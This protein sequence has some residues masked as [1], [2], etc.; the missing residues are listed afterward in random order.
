LVDPRVKP[1]GDKRR[2]SE[3][4]KPQHEDGKE[5]ETEGDKGSTES[6]KGVVDGGAGAGRSG[7]RS[8]RAPTTKRMPTSLAAQ[9]ARTT[10]ASVLRSVIASADRPSPAACSTSSSGCEPPRRNEKLVVT[11][12]SA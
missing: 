4:D 8:N 2:A 11:W 9:W 12:S 7:S 5:Q 10:P 6:R 3:P 1:E